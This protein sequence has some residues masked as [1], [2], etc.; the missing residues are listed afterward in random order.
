M[1]ILTLGL[2]LS[3]L[4]WAQPVLKSLSIYEKKPNYTIT[5]RYPGP[6]AAALR[7]VREEIAAFKREELQPG[8]ILDVNY[9]VV[10]SSAKFTSVLF[11]G[12]A[13]LGGAHP[14][15]I[16]KT[17][18][19]SS[20]GQSIALQ[21]CFQGN[22]W[23]KA[24]ETYCR[25]DLQRQKLDSDKDWIL[26]GTAAKPENY[27]LVLPTSKG[28]RVIF[29]DYQVAPH[30]AGPQEVTVPYSVVAPHINPK[31]PQAGQ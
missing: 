13:N 27:Q 19:L 14:N 9:E 25:Q 10:Y 11:S 24:L 20:T 18:L 23:L 16:Q 12:Y 6:N 28:L 22:G 31:G 2:L 21:Q 4:A 30:A 26:T 15:G 1:R 5:V 3:L 7:L 29:T 17:L 8:C